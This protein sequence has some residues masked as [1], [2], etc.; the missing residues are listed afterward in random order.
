MATLPSNYIFFYKPTQRYIY[1]RWSCTTLPPLYNCWRRSTCSK[2]AQ[3]E[4]RTGTRHPQYITNRGT[5]RV[6]W[7]G[8]E[9][10]DNEYSMASAKECQPSEQ[11]LVFIFLGVTIMKYRRLL[12]PHSKTYREDDSDRKAIEYR[13]VFAGMP[14]FWIANCSLMG[15]VN[16]TT[17]LLHIQIRY[18]KFMVE[19]CTWLRYPLLTSIGHSYIAK[20]P[21]AK[22]HES[23]QCN[24][25]ELQPV[26]YVNRLKCDP[27]NWMCS[28]GGAWVCWAFQIYIELR[29]G[30]WS[31]ASRSSGTRLGPPVYYAPCLCNP[32]VSSDW[33]NMLNERCK[34]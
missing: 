1:T 30:P 24:G 18:P 11:W 3:A 25:P 31:Q 15:P 22:M 17:I 4:P 2:D 34:S 5:R 19:T 33:Y 20:G 28:D 9:F 14:R 16:M 32:L 21:Y 7:W 8:N 10:S 12:M 6:C 27:V 13:G 29:I 26:I 23:T